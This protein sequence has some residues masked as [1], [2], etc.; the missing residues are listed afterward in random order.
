MRFPLADARELAHAARRTAGLRL[1]LAAL[2]I[3]LIAL[4][5]ATSGGSARSRPVPP[6][7]GTNTEIVLDVSGSVSGLTLPPVGRTLRAIQR[8]SGRS[9]TVGLILFSDTAMEALP[10]GTPARELRPF[11]HFFTPIGSSGRDGSTPQ[12]PPNP[13]AI[14]FSDGTKISAGLAAA[15]EALARDHANGRIV[16]ISDLVDD[17]LDRPAVRSEL[18]RDLRN[19]K[20]SVQ[21]VALPTGIFGSDD[22]DMQLYRSLLGRAAVGKSYPVPAAPRAAGT[23][24]GAAGFPG[25]LVGMTLLAAI[26]LASFELVAVTLRWREDRP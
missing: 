16:L 22:S 12:L 15:R 18:V 26:A 20:L 4:A 9:G 24:G 7:P 10:P 5:F 14:S 19:P 13:W 21:V 2:L 23:T 1:G 11:V 8:A 17:T 6:P 25:G 3:G